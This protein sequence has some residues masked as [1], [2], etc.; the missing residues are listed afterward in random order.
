M[1]VGSL[2]LKIAWR[3]MLQKERETGQLQSTE[4]GGGLKGLSMGQIGEGG[5]GGGGYREARDYMY[6]R[7]GKSNRID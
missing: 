2:S 6:C 5:R 1:N 7:N 4:G 3:I